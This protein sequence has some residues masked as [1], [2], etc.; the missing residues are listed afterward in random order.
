M[1]HWVSRICLPFLQ[2]E[3]LPF[4]HPHTSRFT[5]SCFSTRN[6]MHLNLKHNVIRQLGTG[7]ISDLKSSTCR[8]TAS[9]TRP[10]SGIDGPCLPSVASYKITFPNLNHRSIEGVLML[11]SLPKNCTPQ[12]YCPRCWWLNQVRWCYSEHCTLQRQSPQCWS[13]NQGWRCF[14][15]TCSL[16]RHCPECWSLNQVCWCFSKNCTLRRQSPQCSS[17]NQVCWCFPEIRSGQRQRMQCSWLNLGCWCFS[18]TCT[19]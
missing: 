1:S 14:P 4:L 18:K 9:K 7:W 17:L 5:S 13:L 15:K 16:Q 8:K 3:C 12:R 2:L 10:K 11:A 19:L 6:N